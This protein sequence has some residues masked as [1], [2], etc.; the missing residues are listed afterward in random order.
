MKVAFDI[1]G[2][3]MYRFDSEEIMY[4]PK[5]YKDDLFI[6]ESLDATSHFESSAEDVCNIY[7][8]IN[9]KELDMTL[10]EKKEE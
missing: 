10:P 1:L 3:I 9:G 5:E 6:T 7:K 8:A 4:S 2:D